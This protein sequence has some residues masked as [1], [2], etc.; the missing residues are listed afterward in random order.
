MT[1]TARPDAVRIHPDDNVA[2]AIRALSAGEEVTV[3]GILVR[4]KDDIP[5]GHK[6]GL[7]RIEPGEKVVKYGF[8]IGTATA[9]VWDGTWI[10]SH[11][12]RTQLEGMLGYEYAPVAPRETTGLVMPTFEGYRRDDG[13]V[14]TR[15][16]VWI[17]N[18]VGCV[19]FVAE[20]IA[21]NAAASAA[22]NHIDGVYAFGHP[23][24]CSQLGRPP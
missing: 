15:N 19:N 20:G 10:H 17:L 23:F 6:F 2:V 13:R 18:T 4:L 16:E 8:P 21:R 7:G 11:N 12:L 1:T 3:D 24:G 22:A 14:G 9:P 5:A